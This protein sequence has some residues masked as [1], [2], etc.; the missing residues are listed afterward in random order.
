MWIELQRVVLVFDFGKKA[1]AVAGA[2][3]CLFAAVFEVGGAKRHVFLPVICGASLVVKCK[4]V[5][6]R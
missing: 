1:P 2:F 6:L 3:F 4:I 5:A